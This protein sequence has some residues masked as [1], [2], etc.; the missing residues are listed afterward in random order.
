MQERDLRH[1]PYELFHTCMITSYSYLFANIHYLDS[2]QRTLAGQLHPSSRAPASGDFSSP[3]ESTLPDCEAKQR[4]R[5][6]NYRHALATVVIT[7]VVCGIVFLMMLAA[8]VYGCAYAAINARYQRE[9]KRKATEAD[10]EER[11][12]SEKDE[13]KTPLD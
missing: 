13:E 8:A 11:K 7:G 3:G 9:L 5:P 1:I 2:K 12:S 10:G 4:P 6:A